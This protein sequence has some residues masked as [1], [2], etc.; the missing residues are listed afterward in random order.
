MQCLTYEAWLNESSL[1]IHEIVQTV[2]KMGQLPGVLLW[3]FWAC[4]VH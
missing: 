4:I 3:E 2:P 1:F